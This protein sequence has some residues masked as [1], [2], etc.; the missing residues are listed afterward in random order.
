MNYKRCGKVKA[1]NERLK[2]IA[3]MA[4]DIHTRDPLNVREKYGCCGA[5][6]EELLCEKIEEALKGNQKND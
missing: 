3:Q 1:E 4:Y 5:E 2:Y 6:I